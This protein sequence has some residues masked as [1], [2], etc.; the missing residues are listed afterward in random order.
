MGLQT[1]SVTPSVDS[2]VPG[3]RPLS[4]ILGISITLP[5]AIARLFLLFRSGKPRADGSR[6]AI[7]IGRAAAIGK[8]RRGTMLRQPKTQGAAVRRAILRARR[9]TTQFLILAL[10]RRN[11]V[12][13]PI[14]C[15]L[16]NLHPR[17]T[18]LSPLRSAARS[19]ACSSD[20]YRNSWL[21]ITW[22]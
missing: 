6:G 18:T 10:R 20:Q 14:Q 17:Q 11:R 9:R 21:L 5:M 7:G 3:K 12:Q 13:S 8:V 22:R 16:W 19:A 15:R 2:H 1:P 4:N